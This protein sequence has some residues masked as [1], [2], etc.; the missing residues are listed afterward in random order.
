MAHI[1]FIDFE[2][3]GLT[4]CFSNFFTQFQVKI[5]LLFNVL[6]LF[7]GIAAASISSA[8]LAYARI[9]ATVAL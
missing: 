1:S 3:E 4:T 2:V 7:F 9:N 8:M 6:N 5:E